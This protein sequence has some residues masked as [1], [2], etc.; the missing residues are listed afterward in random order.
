MGHGEEEQGE[1]G[2]LSLEGSERGTTPLIRD[3]IL[4]TEAILPATSSSSTPLGL[5]QE[6]TQR[7]KRMTGR[8]LDSLRGQGRAAEVTFPSLLEDVM[9]REREEEEGAPGAPR[10]RRKAVAA[11]VF[12]DLLALASKDTVKVK[13]SGAFE[14][15][16][17]QGKVR[18]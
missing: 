5:S 9:Q 3:A 11:Q 1:E 15:I 10:P 8:V 12:F 6:S 17:V 7:E 14:P 18:N 13:Q 16:Y 4:D 2:M